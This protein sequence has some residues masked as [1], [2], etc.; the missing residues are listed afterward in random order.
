MLPR[1]SNS[2]AFVSLDIFESALTE[3]SNEYRE[4]EDPLL[5]ETLDEVS[6][7]SAVH[8]GARF[9]IV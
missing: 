3:L 2:I 8:V 1:R 6:I 7:S 5:T 9:A 4:V